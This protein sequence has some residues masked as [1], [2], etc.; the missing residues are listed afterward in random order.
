MNRR[1]A[2]QFY[3]MVQSANSH[4]RRLVVEKAQ[5]EEEMERAREAYKRALLAVLTQRKSHAPFLSATQAAGSRA[6][7]R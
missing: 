3:S 7:A 5:Q 6:G 4:V 1:T 2:N